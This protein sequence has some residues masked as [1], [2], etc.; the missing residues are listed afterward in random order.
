MG[1]IQSENGRILVDEI[2]TDRAALWLHNNPDSQ[3]GS[4]SDSAITGTSLA[5][6]KKSLI[7]LRLDSSDIP[8]T[9]TLTG[10]VSLTADG[11]TVTGSGTAFLTELAVN[12]Y[13][14]VA[15][16]ASPTGYR[17]GQVAS[18][19]S[20]TSFTLISAW[21]GATQSGA[22]MRAGV[23]S[24]NGAFQ[25]SLLHLQSKHRIH[26]TSMAIMGL[27]YGPGDWAFVENLVSGGTGIA[28]DIA[29]FELNNSGLYGRVKR[30]EAYQTKINGVSGIG[31]HAQ[32]S[33]SS[34][35]VTGNVLAKLEEKGVGTNRA[36]DIVSRTSTGI[37]IRHDHGAWGSTFDK[38]SGVQFQDWDV[39]LDPA[40]AGDRITGTL[41]IKRVAGTGGAG[42]DSKAELWWDDGAGTQTQIA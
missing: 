42:S 38:A 13:V 27:N 34:S 20:D 11:T 36:L 2:L 14:E 9:T 26:D 17:P 15:D 8:L 6:M 1:Q 33:H 5:A 4:A 28:V 19:A 24:T 23:N 16:S 37:I 21:N 12:D 7:S 10:T 35:S 3:Y 32:V 30:A 22:T 31:F 18:I 40:S 41:F 25:Q 29:E 39:S